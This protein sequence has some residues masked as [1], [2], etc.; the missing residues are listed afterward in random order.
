MASLH[1]DKVNKSFGKD[2]IIKDLSLSIADGSFVVLVGPSGCGKSTLL[3]MIAGLEDITSG[4]LEL[5]GLLANTLPPRRRNT[6]M[7]FQSYALFPHMTV[8]D[9]MAFGPKVRKDPRE[10]IEPRVRAAARMLGLEDYLRHFPRQLSGGQRQRVAMARAVVR[11]AQLFLFDEPLSNLDAKLRVQMRTEIKALHHKLG[12]TFVYVT[13]DQIEAMT[14]AERIVVMRAG[15]IEQMGA[16]LELY[17]YPVN[18]FVAG[19]LGTPAMS[20]LSTTYERSGDGARLCLA[21]DTVLAVPPLAVAGGSAVELGIRPESL[22]P[23]PQGALRF[24]IEVVEPTGAELLCFGTLAGSSV[25]VVVRERLAL[26]PGET[27]NLALD[28][29]RL[30]FFSPETGARLA[31]A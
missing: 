7:V 13:H 30:H 10:E 28:S 19:F 4:R 24:E 31:L 1:L 23:S 20:F 2:E 8:Y 6:A 26:R 22:S 18:R 12:V 14:L 11:A 29:E 5:D 3:R 25:R 27:I 15:R 9:N 21:D 16:P 17:D